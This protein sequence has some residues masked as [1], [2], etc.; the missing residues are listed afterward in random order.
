MGRP[1]LMKTERGLAAAQS[2]PC[3]LM[4]LSGRL[5]R[6]AS[7]SAL[8]VK[9]TSWICLAMSA[10]DPLRTSSALD[11]RECSVCRQGRF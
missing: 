1:S 6:W 3:L 7:M 8:R 9:Q 2:L 10:N 4:A 11:A 5:C